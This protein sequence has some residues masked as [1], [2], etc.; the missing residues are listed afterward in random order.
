MLKAYRVSFFKAIL[1]S[2]GHPFHA[3][4]GTV[5]VRATSQEDGVRKGRK[6]FAA[7]KGANDWSFHAD[8]ETVEAIPP[9]PAVRSRTGAFG[10]GSPRSVASRA[11]RE[12]A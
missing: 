10:T 3:V 5:E 11:V 8:Y 9:S 4:Q 12:A 1:D 6:A 7:L 2:T